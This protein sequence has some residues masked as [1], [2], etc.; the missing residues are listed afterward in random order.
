MIALAE[1]LDREGSCTLQVL[2][3][4]GN[5]LMKK[6]SDRLTAAYE[7]GALSTLNLG[8]SYH[9]RQKDGA[10]WGA[11]NDRFVVICSKQGTGLGPL[12][13]KCKVTFKQEDDEI[14]V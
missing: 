13:M 3:M 4:A 6:G 1:A 12:T 8:V 5:P 14:E 11:S 7:K 9:S 2:N 10:D